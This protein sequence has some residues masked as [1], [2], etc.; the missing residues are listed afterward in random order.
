MQKFIG[1]I[2]A[3]SLMFVGTGVFAAVGVV[4]YQKVAQAISFQKAMTDRMQSATA[5]SRKTVTE[6]SAQISAKE[7]E[8][9]D[10][11]ATL[12]ADQKKALESGLANLR[13]S[14]TKAQSDM[15]TKMMSLRQSLGDEI[16]TS[17]EKTLGAIAAKH[18]LE[19][20]Y[21]TMGLAYAK[22]KVDLTE[23]LITELAKT[24]GRVEA[25]PNPM[26]K[27]GMRG[28]IQE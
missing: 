13:A 18:N 24:Y 21:T 15:Q 14:L 23:E 6:M 28:K 10:K 25:N 11:A 8:L 1:A 26:M 7:K 3:G 22:D 16:K 19:S 4:D 9:K 27:P 2:L 20:V 17:L 12:S 5:D